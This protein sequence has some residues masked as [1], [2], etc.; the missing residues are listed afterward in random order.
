LTVLVFPVNEFRRHLLHGREREQSAATERINVV[1]DIPRVIDFLLR[2]TPQFYLGC[3]S[4]MGLHFLK[5]KGFQRNMNL[6]AFAGLLA[7]QKPKIQA[8][9]AARR[10]LARKFNL[11]N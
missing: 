7:A 1:D 8:R 5:R 4:Q 11:V 3:H 10:N 9:I 2:L 6:R